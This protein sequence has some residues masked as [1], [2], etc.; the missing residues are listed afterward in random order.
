MKKM[1]I[2]AAMGLTVSMLVSGMA[3]AA[4]SEVPTFDELDKN[5]DGQLSVEEVSNAPQVSE[6]WTEIDADE[7]GTVDRI[8]FS[9]F[10][11][12]NETGAEATMEEGQA[13]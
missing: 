5:L 6:Q 12:H 10:E 9:A 3:L 13:N 7:S 11:T 2:A 1:S 4:G 8:E